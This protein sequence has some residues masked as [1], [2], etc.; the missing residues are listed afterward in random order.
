MA[1]VTGED[2]LPP[3]LATDTRCQLLAQLASRLQQIDLTPLLVYLID[4]TEARALPH[5]AE[6]F[7]LTGD[8]GWQLA[9]SEEAKRKLI[10]SAI[11]LHRLKGT[12][13]A[14]R[15]VIR[16]LGF[17]EVQLLEGSAG[18]EEHLLENYPK[19]T[20]WALYRVVLSQALTND[21]AASLRKTLVSFAPARCEL[22]S[23]DYTAV[24]IRYNNQARY[25]GQYNHGS[26]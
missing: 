11:E 19:E 10:K 1:N 20:R 6:Q 24:P 8:N 21:Q 14:V 2:L 4:L 16:N 17:G 15:E 7:A 23:L 3:P 26:G 25:D 9:E 13:W 22:F 18:I 12:P 5:L